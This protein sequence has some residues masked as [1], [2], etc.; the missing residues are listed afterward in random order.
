MQS[1]LQVSLQAIT[2]SAVSVD[3]KLLS[4]DIYDFI[5]IDSGVLI[6]S[7][8]GTTARDK[9]FNSCLEKVFSR[10]VCHDLNRSTTVDVVWD[11]YPALE[12]KESTREKRETGIRVHLLVLPQSQ[13]P[14]RIFCC[15]L[16]TRKYYS[17]FCQKR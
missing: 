15:K 7:L 13:K 14:G 9:T 6:H 10:R 12:I 2:N 4:P 5:N 3:K 16:V 8:S 11:Q 1:F 17:H